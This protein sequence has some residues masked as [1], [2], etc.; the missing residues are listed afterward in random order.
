MEEAFSLTRRPCAASPE[1]ML[2]WLLEPIQ[3]VVS[4]WRNL[5]MNSPQASVAI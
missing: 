5:L 1:S 2:A 3:Y 4:M